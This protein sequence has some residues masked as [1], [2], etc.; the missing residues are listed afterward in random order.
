[1]LSLTK[2]AEYALIAVCHL[3]RGEGQ[4]VSA[5]ELA[6]RYELSQ[7]LLTNALKLL[8]QEGVL[9]SER[10]P[11]GGYALE[12]GPEAIT[13]ERLIEA[14]EGPVRLVRCVEP[15]DEAESECDLLESCPIRHPVHKVHEKLGAFLRCVT[16]ADLAFDDDFVERE[17]PERGLRVVTK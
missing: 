10:G 4:V 2:R 11:R 3:A 16:V 7:P 17:C 12:V 8:A 15:L 1:M 5:R 14:V 13:L 6:S 9:R